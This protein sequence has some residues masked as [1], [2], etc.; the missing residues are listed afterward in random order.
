M[1]A[2]PIYAVYCTTGVYGIG[3]CPVKANNKTEARKKFKKRFPKSKI[4]SIDKSERKS[5]IIDPI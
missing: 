5:H 3:C 2:K 4:I 1:K